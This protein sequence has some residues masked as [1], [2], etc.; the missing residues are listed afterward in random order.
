MLMVF[1]TFMMRYGIR[2][3][4]YLPNP[5]IN[6]VDNIILPRKTVIH[7]LDQT[8]D[9][10]FPNRNMSYFKDVAS[11]KKIRVMNLEDL[12]V[13]EGIQNFENRY[14]EKD[15][16]Q[17]GASHLD[18]F[19]RQDLF[20]EPQD[21][22]HNL[23]VFNYNTLKTLYT[24]RSSNLLNYNKN[25][26]LL[27]TYSDTLKKALNT[28]KQNNQHITLNL[29]NSIPGYNPMEKLINYGKGKL[30]RRV[31]ETS[32]FWIIEWYKWLVD[33]TRSNS[34]FKSITDE[35][36]KRILVEIR[37]RGYV[38]YLK[39]STLRGLS[40]NS[41]LDSPKKF[42]DNKLRKFFLSFL[43]DLQ[44]KMAEL[45][46]SNTI[47]ER[48]LK[49]DVD[50][51][52]V[53][54]EE[55]ETDVQ[56]VIEDDLNGP[57]AEPEEVINN[58]IEKEAKEKPKDE[59]PINDLS[60][61]D[62]F[63]EIA[64]SMFD[65]KEDD[66]DKYFDSLDKNDDIGKSIVE[67]KEKSNK[68]G[69]VSNKEVDGDEEVE[70]VEVDKLT[71][72][73]VLNIEEESKLL[74]TPTLDDKID[75]YISEG[76]A[77]GTISTGEVRT[78]RLA[79][80]KRK[81]LK[82]PFGNTP[83]DKYKVSSVPDI[84][85]DETTTK[86]KTKDLPIAEN[87]LVK[88][89]A[90]FDE[91]YVENQLNVDVI[92]SIMAIENS[93]AIITNITVEEVKS[94]VDNYQ[95]HKIEIRPL[96]GAPST[97]YQRIPIIDKEGTFMVGGRKYRLRKAKQ[98]LPIRKIT[99][100]RVALT[101]NYGKFFVSRTTRKAYDTDTYVL[102]TIKKRYMNGEGNVTQIVPGRKRLNKLTKVPNL[103]IK[104][105][106]EL[107]SLT[108][109]EFVFDFNWNEIGNI[110]EEKILKDIAKNK[111]VFIGYTNNKDKNIVVMDNNNMLYN[112][113][114]KEKLGTFYSAVDID[115]SKVP[116]SFSVVTAIGKE[117]PLGIVFG[118]Y[119]G[120]TNLLSITKT[121]FRLLASN[122]RLTD[123]ADNE[124]AF[125]FND[126]RLILELDTE[127]KRL[128]FNGFNYYKDF[129]KQYPLSSFDDK[130]IY[131]PLVEYR[132]AALFQLL[133]LDDLD[134][135]FLDPITKEVLRDMKEPDEFRRLLFRA[136]EMLKDYSYP[137]INDP[138]FSRIR[139]YDRVPGLMYRA[140]A[141]TMREHRLTGRANSKVALDPYKVWNYITQD[142]S[143]Q[144][145][146]AVNPLASCK[147][148]EIV[149]LTGRDGLSTIAVPKEMRRFHENDTG[150]FSESTSDSKNV[151]ISAGL[152][153]Y[154]KI[155]NIRGIV[156]EGFKD[157]EENPAKVFSSA[158]QAAPFA[159]FDDQENYL[160]EVYGSA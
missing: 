135:L 82:E 40:E 81:R 160:D 107:N 151:A 137:D 54:E 86:I 1:E 77:T 83:I 102:D 52:P 91:E 15:I 140:L 153:P 92:D 18:S 51:N 60:D 97:L 11:A 25:Y 126:Y 122:K 14:L 147:E 118:Y 159:E 32:L 41:S 35:D 149:T 116:Q 141:E 134:D 85:L 36:S 64:G 111:L 90:K 115:F 103:Y 28:D 101:S 113:G 44:E 136:N 143:V 22:E 80:E 125:R 59:L 6:R 10:K 73:P 24:Y 76:E 150:L 112:Y 114:T 61:F 100:I 20:E 96:K 95:L 79:Q 34:V 106:G 152:S 155:E 19:R 104:L 27:F 50:L 49:D 144:A 55:A 94:S 66:L 93:G 26:N 154:A 127:E 138:N 88:K 72:A 38:T 65:D 46:L 84:K 21:D 29:P 37:F 146:E 121:K 63:D 12:T 17:W 139:G 123:L 43:I 67:E 48:P 3:A 9:V 13:K 30:A 130:S 99:P 98:D 62:K 131:L 145:R 70:L 68:K 16:R 74:D 33:E 7:Y 4:L 110:V 157:T 23:G 129:I 124:V 47:I 56:D 78:L 75:R 108:T 142:S 57:G 53:M 69:L 109:K 5:V 42:N 133:Y 31:N 87:M 156:T 117:I 45:A 105:A 148:D 58:L 2:N 119:M 71:E 132:G 158:V 120:L 128:L 89:I 8:I 39:L